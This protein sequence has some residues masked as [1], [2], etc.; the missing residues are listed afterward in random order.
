MA[1]EVLTRRYS[2]SRNHFL[3]SYNPEYCESSF[4]NSLAR[5]QFEGGWSYKKREGTL[6]ILARVHREVGP[7]S[8][9]VG[10]NRIGTS[11]SRTDTEGNIGRSRVPEFRASFQ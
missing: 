5:A 4:L 10:G 6:H 9:R 8:A 1:I 2:R 7:S 11:G 3:L